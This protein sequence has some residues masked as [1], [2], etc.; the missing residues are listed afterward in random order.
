MHRAALLML[1]LLGA[2][3]STDT[4]RENFLEGDRPRSV[5]SKSDTGACKPWFV[6]PS[7]DW[8]D[9]A[10]KHSCWNRMWE[11]PCA[12]I[13]APIAIAIVTIPIW[14]PIILLH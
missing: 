6:S 7:R 1:V 12:L 3:A 10:P 2:C 5:S 13:V 8:G 4:E 11:V 9:G 14:V